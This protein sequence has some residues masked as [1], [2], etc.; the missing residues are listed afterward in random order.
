MQDEKT[1]EI[2]TRFPNNTKSESLEEGFQTKVDGGGDGG[3]GGGG[4]GGRVS[5]ITWFSSQWVN[6]HS[7]AN[8]YLRLIE[9]QK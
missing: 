6:I 4:W 7:R 2:F 3:G 5:T 8:D 9:N 1:W